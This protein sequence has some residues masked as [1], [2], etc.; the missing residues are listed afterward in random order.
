MSYFVVN[1]LVATVL[2][3]LIYTIKTLTDTINR[4]S[5]IIEVLR[6]YVHNGNTR[7]VELEKTVDVTLKTTREATDHI[8]T[9]LSDIHTEVK[10]PVKKKTIAKKD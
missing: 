8:Y 9:I 2:A 10:K 3:G 4:Q 6:D 7:L 1:I 5:K